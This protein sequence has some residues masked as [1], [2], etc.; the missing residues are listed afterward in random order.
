M[1][2]SPLEQVLHEH[3]LPRD[4]RLVRGH[5]PPLL[6]HQ[7]DVTELVGVQATRVEGHLVAGVLLR[8]ERPHQGGLGRWVDG[9]EG[10]SSGVA[11]R[12]EVAH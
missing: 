5:R 6:A 9:F 1:H 10:G 11:W 4:D 2:L 3:R 8:V 12:V 7:D